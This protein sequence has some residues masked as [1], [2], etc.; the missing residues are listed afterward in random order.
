MIFVS[1][2]AKQIWLPNAYTLYFQRMKDVVVIGGGLAGL[3]SSI[4]LSRAGLDVTVV[5]KKKYPFHRVC[6]EYVSNEVVP[7][8]K[9]N[10]LYPQEHAPTSINKF[11]L[12]AISGSKAS[13]KLDVG[14]FG[15]SRFTFDHFLYQKALA[16]GVAF[17]IGLVADRVDREE[18]HFVVSYSNGGRE[19]ASLVIGAHGKRSRIDKSLDREFIQRRSPFLAV[20]YHIKTDFPAD[21]VGLH[22]FPGGY[23]GISRVEN[24]VYNLCYLSRT[25]NLRAFGRIDDMEEAVLFQNPELKSLFSNADFLIAPEVINEVSFEKKQLVESGIFMSGDAAGLITPLC[26]NGMAMAIHSAKLLSEAIIAHRSPDG[27][28]HERIGQH[29]GVRWQKNFSNRL[30]AGRR[31]QY[32]FGQRLTSEFAVGLLRYTPPVARAIISQTHGRPF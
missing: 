21:T 4:L 7:F 10:G 27:F 14:G 6:G 25:E 13:V 28:D 31:S 3:V 20:K 5:E 15:I 8:L 23:C 9:A 29:Y 18:D 12:S 2:G 11:Q 30:W 19:P 1:P 22:N 16:S 26:G 24:D 32:L 17:K